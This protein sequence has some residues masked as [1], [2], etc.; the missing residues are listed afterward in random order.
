MRSGRIL[1]LLLA[2][3]FF[4]GFKP[5]SPVFFQMNAILDIIAS[6]GLKN[7][8]FRDPDRP[9]IDWRGVHHIVQSCHCF[10]YECSYCA[11]HKSSYLSIYCVLAVS[12]VPVGTLLLQQPAHLGEVPMLIMLKWI[13]RHC[14]FRS[15]WWSHGI[16]YPT[17]CLLIQ[18]TCC[19]CDFSTFRMVNSQGRVGFS[20]CLSTLEDTAIVGFFTSRTFCGATMFFPC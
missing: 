19:W 14:I 1:R 4:C 20:H 5:L 15:W 3:D 9:L 17:N 11:M 18:P 6:S 12:L 7:L 16:Y 2:N 8:S 13:C 10:V